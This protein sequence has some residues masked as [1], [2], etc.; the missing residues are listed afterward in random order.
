MV[1]ADLLGIECLRHAGVGVTDDGDVV[2]PLSKRVENVERLEFEV[3]THRGRGEEAL[4]GTPLVAS[5]GTV[6]FLDAHE[7]SLVHLSSRPVAETT[8]GNHGVQ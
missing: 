2:L 8:G 6:H 1:P 4:L 5:S 7:P 3:L